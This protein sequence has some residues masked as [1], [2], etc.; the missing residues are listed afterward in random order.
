MTNQQPVDVTF[1]YRL[2]SLETTRS[3]RYQVISQSHAVLYSRKG[4]CV[5]SFS[6]RCLYIQHVEPVCAPQG[7][8][9]LFQHLFLMFLPFS[10]PWRVVLG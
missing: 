4:A 1:Y 10:P 7:E 2:S 5:S 9:P 6:R 3:S 8:G